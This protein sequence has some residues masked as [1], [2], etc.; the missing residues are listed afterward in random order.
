MNNFQNNEPLKVESNNSGIKTIIVLVLIIV[1]IGVVIWLFTGK[2]FNKD[3]SNTTTNNNS[4]SLYILSE[5][6][7]ERKSRFKY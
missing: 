1:A 4:N 3:N 7:C 2:S 6:I 5:C